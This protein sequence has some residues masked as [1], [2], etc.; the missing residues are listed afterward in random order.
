M[1]NSLAGQVRNSSEEYQRIIKYNSYF[2]YVLDRVDD[3][4]RFLRWF[5]FV[6]S[7]NPKT[8]GKIT[9]IIHPYLHIG[10]N[11]QVTLVGAL[12]F[13][14]QLQRAAHEVNIKPPGRVIVSYPY[15]KLKSPGTGYEALI[16]LPHP[17]YWKRAP[18]K[19]KSKIVRLPIRN[20]NLR[21]RYWDNK[22]TKLIP[23]LVKA[24]ME[25]HKDVPMNSILESI[26]A[27]Y[28]KY[29]VKGG[30][31]DTVS[32]RSVRMVGKDDN[33]QTELDLFVLDKDNGP[34]AEI[35]EV[36]TADGLNDPESIFKRKI[37]TQEGVIRFFNKN[38][39]PVGYH[40]VI[41]GS[42][43][44]QLRLALNVAKETLIESSLPLK[45]AGVHGVYYKGRRVYPYY[46]E[47]LHI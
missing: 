47:I 45:E 40:F 31:T 42:N 27:Y 3:K 41:V 10:E 19:E 2:R 28:V 13:L 30:R 5:G 20:I 14:S 11:K 8:P 16:I 39:I 37:R 1:K 26:G 36:K 23:V 35:Y 46:M 12:E 34:K 29:H 7:Y 43:K 4:E 38:R 32:L 9:Y 18:K 44:E 24:H 33:D 15:H 25:G 22:E 21:L 17:Y 6:P